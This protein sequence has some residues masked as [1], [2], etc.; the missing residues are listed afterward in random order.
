M[1]KLATVFSGIGAIEQALEKQKINYTIE[2]ACDNGERE[3]KNTKEEIE[4]NI[5]NL[6]DIEKKIYIDNLY[7]N[8]NKTN[9]VQESY[10]ANYDVSEENFYQ[11]FGRKLREVYP[12]IV[13]RLEKQGLLICRKEKEGETGRIALSEF[14]LDVSNIVMAE[15]LL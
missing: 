11:T 7:K 3:L 5:K 1:I 2:F 4:N 8:L 14:G 6:N 13:E 12:G 9:Y 15:F 10:M